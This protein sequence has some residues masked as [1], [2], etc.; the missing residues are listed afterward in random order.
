MLTEWMRVFC[1]FFDRNASQI[2]AVMYAEGCREGWLQG[3]MFRQSEDEDFMVNSYKIGSRGKAL[4]LHGFRP[5]SSSSP[6]TMVGEIKIIATSFLNKNIAGRSNISEFIKSDK[7]IVTQSHLDSVH[8][9]EGSLLKDI[10]RL[11]GILDQ[12]IEKY[13][14]LVIPEY[15]SD[16]VNVNLKKALFGVE[17]SS[18]HVKREY[19]DD[20]FSVRIWKI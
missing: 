5:R 10:V 17:I 7:T 2:G 14:I 3:E 15:E 16:E 1:E 4:D 12:D 9:K 18:I 13:M 11:K 20:H 19:P 8:P 6:Q